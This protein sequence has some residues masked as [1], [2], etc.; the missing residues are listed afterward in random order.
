MIGWLDTYILYMIRKYRLTTAFVQMI[1]ISIESWIPS[2]DIISFNK[3]K[4]QSHTI[5]ENG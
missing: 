5:S 4:S 1:M 3:V 2:Q